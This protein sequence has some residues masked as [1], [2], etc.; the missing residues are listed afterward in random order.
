MKTS[1]SRQWLF[2]KISLAIIFLITIYYYFYVA[3]QKYSS[4]ICK[5]IYCLEIIKIE[6]CISIVISLIGLTIVLLT[7][8]T[9]K[10]QIN[11]QNFCNSIDNIINDLQSQVAEMNSNYYKINTLSIKELNK[12]M[13]EEE[14]VLICKNEAFN[15][16]YTIG[17]LERNTEIKINSIINEIKKNQD[18]EETTKQLL[19]NYMDNYKE[20]GKHTDKIINDIDKWSILKE[21]LILLKTN[22]V[23]TR[24]N[25]YELINDLWRHKNLK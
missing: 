13:T 23:V 16:F 11:H 3:I 2:L 4:T 6:D 5:N 22:L 12:N 24:D 7:I 8:N 15:M 14:I 18:Y 20:R 17:A 1:N 19:N 21:E 10:H 9:W 25:L